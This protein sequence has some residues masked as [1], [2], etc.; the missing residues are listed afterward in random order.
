MPFPTFSGTFGPL[1]GISLYGNRA[2]LRKY[3]KI[4]KLFNHLQRHEF[5]QFSMFLF[6]VHK[7]IFQYKKIVHSNSNPPR[8]S[9]CWLHKLVMFY[10]ISNFFKW[11]R[12]H[13][14]LQKMLHRTVV[15]KFSTDKRKSQK[16]KLNIKRLIRVTQ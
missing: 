11:T 14:S 12:W 6:I 3:E 7:E 10:Q 16:Q 4:H 8:K 13:P 9:S 5:L 2:K 1:R 15:M